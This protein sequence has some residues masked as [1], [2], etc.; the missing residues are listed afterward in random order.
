MSIKG[1]IQSRLGSQPIRGKLRSKF[2]GQPTGFRKGKTL[3]GATQRMRNLRARS[4]TSGQIGHPISF[5][6]PKLGMQSIG[7][8]IPKPFGGKIYYKVSYWYGRI[9]AK[10]PIPKLLKG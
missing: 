6:R 4:P 7:G 1:K 5:P 3:E 9:R 2:G 10:I 8:R